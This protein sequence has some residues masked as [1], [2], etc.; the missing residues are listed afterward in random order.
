MTHSL[1][2]LYRAIDDDLPEQ[3]REI[4]DAKK[5]LADA[6]QETPPPVHWAIFRDRLRIAELILDYGADIERKDQD[7]DATP[8]DYAIMYGRKD[9]VR[10]LIERNAN[11]EGRLQLA[12]RAAAGAYE[13]YSDLPS[14][15]VYQEVA[16]VMQ[17]MLEPT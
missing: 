16:A 11:T 15:D 7:R 10:M 17:D 8:L 3:V 4:L 13:E 14:L 6:S 9:I 2:G 1:E 5:Q 12:L